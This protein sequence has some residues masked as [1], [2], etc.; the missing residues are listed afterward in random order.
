L[1][2]LRLQNDVPMIIP[3]L[4]SLLEASCL[5]CRG[6]FHPGEDDIVPPLSNGGVAKTVVLVGNIGP[7]MWQKFRHSP[8]N[9]DTRANP[10]DRWTKRILEEIILH[11]DAFGLVETLYPFGGPPYLPFQK[12]AQRA[13]PV[14]PSPTGPLIHPTYG[15]WHAYRG[16]F[17][18]EE[19]LELPTIDMIQSPCESCSDRPCL[20][21]CPVNAFDGTHYDVP[22]CTAHM[23]HDPAGET[24][25]T[26]GCLARHACPVGNEY[27]YEAAQSE[28]HTGAFLRAQQ[29]DNT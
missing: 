28:F 21:A 2:T 9:L 15:L 17:A 25:Q 11:A 29:A 16:A 12:W 23:L 3:V 5:S 26:T 27:T 6:G 24:C 14:Y 19:R 13:E 1:F 18:F 10:L 4:A 8:E 7:H 22:A 20:N